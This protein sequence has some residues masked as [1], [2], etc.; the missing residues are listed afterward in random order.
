MYSIFDL[1]IPC[2]ERTA[3]WK[4]PEETMICEQGNCIP[5]KKLFIKNIH[6]YFNIKNFNIKNCVKNK[7]KFKNLNLNFLN[8]K[9]F[10][11]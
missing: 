2:A 4:C 7:S 10:N 6:Y 3:E 9:Y 11:T 1:D 8:K 5:S